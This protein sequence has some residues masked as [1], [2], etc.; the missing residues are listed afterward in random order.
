[1]FMLTWE[2]VKYDSIESAVTLPAIHSSITNSR[3]QE[4]DDEL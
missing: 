4:L 2:R 1:M 3:F